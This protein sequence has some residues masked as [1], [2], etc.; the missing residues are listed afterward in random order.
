[1]YAFFL[2]DFSTYNREHSWSSGDELLNNFATTLKN[3]FTNSLIFR[4]FGDDFV[5][6]THNEFEIDELENGLDQIVKDTNIEY[7][8]KKID[9]SKVD[10]NSSEEIENF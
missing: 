6:L 5:A 7:V 8:L 4:V 1:M 9:I 3:F 2:K 10:I